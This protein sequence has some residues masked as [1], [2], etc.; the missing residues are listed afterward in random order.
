MIDDVEA[1]T[2]QF[3]ARLGAKLQIWD[4]LFVLRLKIAT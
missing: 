1:R 2:V 4:D 3:E